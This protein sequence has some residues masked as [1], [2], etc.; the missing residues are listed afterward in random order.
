MT[1]R[2]FL[3][4]IL[5]LVLVLGLAVLPAAGAEANILWLPEEVQFCTEIGYSYNSQLGWLNVSLDKWGMEYALYDLNTGT[6]VE[7]FDGVG[8]FSEGLAQ[9]FK[10]DKCGYIDTTGKVVIPLVLDAA[11][12][13]QDGV[14]LAIMEWPMPDDSVYLLYYLINTQGQ[15]IAQLDY[16]TVSD[17]SEG[18]ALVERNGKYGFIDKTGQAV[19]PLEYDSAWSFS[20]GRA[21]VEIGGKWGFIDKT[22]NVVISPDYDEVHSFSEGLAAVSLG[23]RYG[24]INTAGEMVVPLE[25]EAYVDDFSEGLAAIYR[26]D[27]SGMWQFGFVNAVGEEIIPPQYDYVSSFSS[28]LAAVSMGSKTDFIDATG[29]V[30]IPLVYDSAWDFEGG[31]A[32]VWKDGKCGY[33]DKSGNEVV[34]CLYDYGQSIGENGDYENGRYRY[35]EDNGRFGLVLD[36]TWQDP[37]VLPPDIPWGTWGATA[38]PST[39]AV[40][41]DGVAVEFQMYALKDE[42]GNDTN[43]IKL[44]D[45]AAVLNFFDVT[46]DGSVSIDTGRSY[47]P[48]GTEHQ[49]PFSGPQ[50][51]VGNSATGVRIDGE[52]TYL[53]TFVITDTT[54][55]GYTYFRLRDLGKALGFQVGWTTQCGV[56]VETDKP[57]SE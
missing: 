27:S 6:F 37:T 11:W 52:M 40:D 44:R 51:C 26:E 56:Y 9:V 46:W 18:L 57:Y 21:A 19:I 25:Y 39:Q 14:A 36:P 30:V 5:A 49:T 1:P 41:I 35:V 8:P 53:Q 3:T 55:G 15:V 54:G 2:K 34:P 50:D 48:N 31:L 47:T 33:I 7:D 16:D 22:G 13:F 20:N 10:D 17:F 32:L 12:D 29:Q 28:G 43:Y 4:L 42:N 23:G 24:Y 45:L 38:Y